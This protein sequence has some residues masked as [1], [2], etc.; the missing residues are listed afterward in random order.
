MIL[1]E[2]GR[3]MTSLRRTPAL[4]SFLGLLTC[5]TITLCLTLGL[6][7]EALAAPENSKTPITVYRDPSCHCCEGWVKHLTAQGFSTQVIAIDDADRLNALKQQHDIPSDLTSCHMALVDGYV[8]EGHVPVRDIQRLLIERPPVAGIA[9]PGMPVGTPG[10][11]DGDQHDP[12][13]VFSFD[14]Q[15]HAE[16]FERVN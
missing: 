9:V 1:R 6:E 15:G 2:F 11:E 4:L 14:H 12:F 8:L 3:Y 13:T 5:L 10:M 16:V 7:A